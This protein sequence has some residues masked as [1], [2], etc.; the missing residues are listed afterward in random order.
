VYHGKIYKKDIKSD[1]V[2]WNPQ[3]I[4]KPHKILV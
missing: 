2:Q 4:L 3:K 1:I